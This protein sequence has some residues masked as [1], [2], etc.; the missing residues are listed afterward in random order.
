MAVQCLF[1]L[2]YFTCQMHCPSVALQREITVYWDV[3]LSL[4]SNS[5]SNVPFYIES[6]IQ[7]WKVWLHQYFPL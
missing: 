6:H 5:W 1:L 7:G 3:F 4:K 2:L